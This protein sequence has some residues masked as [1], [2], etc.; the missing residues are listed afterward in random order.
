MNEFLLIFRKDP[1]VDA[2]LSPTAMQDSIQPWLDWLK[3]LEEKGSLVDGK[4]LQPAGAVIK[5]GKV[6]TNGPYAEIKEVIGGIIVVKATDIDAAMEIGKG[7]PVLGAPWYGTVEVR[8]LL[9]Q[10]G[11]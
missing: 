3:G 5:P 8:Q 10:N 9:Q 7:C 11:H 6:V 2:A 1:A 4:R